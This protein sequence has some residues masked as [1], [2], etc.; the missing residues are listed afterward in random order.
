MQK[1]N[2]QL[3]LDVQKRPIKVLQYGEGN[4]LRAFV[5]WQID[6]L[7]STTGF[8]GGVAVVQ[9]IPIGMTDHLN[10][11]DGLYTLILQGIKDGKATQERSVIKSIHAAVNPYTDFEKYQSL[12]RIPSLRFIFSNTTEAGITF[13]EG[14]EISDRPPIGFPAKL[15]AFLYERFLHFN[16]DTHKGCVIIPCEL[17]DRNGEKLKELV[18]CYAKLWKLDE[19]FLDWLEEANTFCCSL[20]D[21]IVTGYPRDTIGEI[22]EELGYEDALVDVGEYYHLWVIEGPAQV[23]LEFPVESAGLNVKFVEDLTPYRTRKVHIL[24]GAHTTLVPVAYLW[25][26]ETVR[27]S[28]EHEIVGRFL[29]EALYEE[30]VPTLDLPAEELTEYAVSVMNRFCNPFVRHFLMSIALN[31]ISKFKTRVLPSI[32]EYINRKNELPRKL[33]FSLAALLE[34]YKGRRGEEEILL[35]DEDE[36]LHFFRDVWD[37]CDRTEKGIRD[38]V[39]TVLSRK[40]FW[41]TNLCLIKGMTETVS[42]YLYSIDSTGIRE[43]I[44]KVLL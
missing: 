22:T 17:I 23:A 1:L 44:G 38:L 8:N 4:F 7:N 30:I 28:V 11:Q 42:G 25:G 2:K 9:P 3:V 43:A 16:G 10:E 37:G 35:N 20:V 6:L 13:H 41:G 21:R 39:E 27:E 26:L 31:S 15:T 40:D 29:R 18:L 34:F 32:L 5:D 14:D 12:A 36:V 19:Q 24:N 33:L